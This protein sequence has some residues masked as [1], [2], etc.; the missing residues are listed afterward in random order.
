[1]LAA[2]MHVVLLLGALVAGFGSAFAPLAVAAFMPEK[3]K[4]GLPSLLGAFC[5]YVFFL[6]LNGVTE[7]FASAA[8]DGARLRAAAAQLAAGAALGG[9][10]ASW[11]VPRWGP[12]A[13]ISLNCANM[14]L[15]A[16][17]SLAYAARR[18]ALAGGEPRGLLA[19]ALPRGATAALL[20][21]LVAAAHALARAW[22]G[23][24]LARQL[25]GAAALGFA[26]LAGVAVLEGGRMRDARELLKAAA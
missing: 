19:S 25:G 1:V 12:L 21:A 20:G 15:R 13:L 3:G 9:A 6:A 24:G 18:V 17:S 26:A 2:V 8:A 22:G 5:V 11:A 14:A 7:A 16:T 10:A 4:G 23:G